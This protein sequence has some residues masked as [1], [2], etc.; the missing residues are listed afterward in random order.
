MVEIFLLDKVAVPKGL[1]SGVEQLAASVELKTMGKE[2]PIAIIGV[3]VVLKCGCKE[4]VEQFQA[5]EEEHV[6][7]YFHQAYSR[8]K[9]EGYIASTVRDFLKSNAV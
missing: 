1:Y 7:S 9:D 3:Y 6:S 8:I 4:K 2:K 5:K